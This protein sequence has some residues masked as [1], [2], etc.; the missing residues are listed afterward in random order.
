MEVQKST[1]L[2]LIKKNVIR[3]MKN[4]YKSMVITKFKFFQATETRKA[5]ALKDVP[6]YNESSQQKMSSN[7]K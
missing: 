6:E 1:M 4:H 5:S 3:S 2:Q 7:D